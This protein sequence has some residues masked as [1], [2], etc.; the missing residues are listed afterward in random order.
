MHEGVGSTLSNKQ[1][2]KIFYFN[3][4][5]NRCEKENKITSSMK[6]IRSPA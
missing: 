6:V 3:P 1:I 5:K 2:N 4:Q